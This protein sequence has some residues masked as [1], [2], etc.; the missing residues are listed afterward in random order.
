MKNI[1]VI[2]ELVDYFN[3]TKRHYSLTKG[4]YLAEGFSKLLNCYYLTTGQSEK[5][6]NINLINLEC[7]NNDFL[8]EID[9]VLF[10]REMNLIQIIDS[11]KFLKNMLFNKNRNQIICIKGDTFSFLYAKKYK[12]YK[13]EFTKKYNLKFMDFC[14][15]AFDVICCQTKEYKDIALNHIKVR[16]PKYYEFIKSKIFISRM[17]IPN[18]YPLDFNIKNPYDINH[19]YCCNTFNDLGK[20]KALHPICYTDRCS[21]FNSTKS[22]INYN[23]PKIK[24][25][26]MGR[27]KT[28]GGKILFLMRDIMKKLG[29]KYELH[30]FPG[31][32]VIPNCSV[33]VFSPKFPSNLEILRDSIFCT[34]NNVIIHYPYDDNDKTKYVQYADIGID[35]SSTRPKNKKTTAGNTKL[36][37]YCYYG[38]KVV[39][40][41]NVNN[42]HLVQA[43]KNGILLHGI[44]SVDDY[45]TAI[46]KLKNT[47]I[48]RNYTINTTIKNNSWDIIAKELYDKFEKI[49]LLKTNL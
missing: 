3:T 25:I 12:F 47:K 19:N 1:L 7:I 44:A 26:Y 10:I 20:D 29:E 18:V 17:G 33:S 6:G 22:R 14:K 41:E 11:N 15:D 35:F 40:E 28:D 30:I 23:V 49:Y 48:D 37:E 16:Y 46:K 38:L 9:I 34:C 13:E 21:K 32:F 39:T 2:S 43:G 4:F 5:Y 36:L 45:V 27:I 8:K 24:I 31:R 42:F